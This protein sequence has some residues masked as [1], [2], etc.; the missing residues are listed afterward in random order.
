MIDF[1][2]KK[3]TISLNPDFVYLLNNF[4][5]NST[6]ERLQARVIPSMFFQNRKILNRKQQSIRNRLLFSI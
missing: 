6:N 3:L 5:E 4:D 1:E 2:D